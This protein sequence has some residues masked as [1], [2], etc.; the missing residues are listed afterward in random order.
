[1]N[2]CPEAVLNVF[3]EQFEFPAKTLFGVVSTRNQEGTNVRMMRIYDIN[4][5]GHVILTTHTDSLKW[6]EFAATFRVAI[7]FV[8]EDKRT[9]VILRG[10]IKL[11]T[12][13]SLPEMSAMYWGRIRPDVK[14]IYDPVY[15]VDRP[16]QITPPLTVSEKVPK[17]SGIVTIM[18]DFWETLELTIPYTES[19]R[20]QFKLAST[21]WSQEQM[22]VG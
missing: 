7:C 15:N 18:P 3:K 22:N 2:C 17:T 20:F 13:Q 16:Y 8:S 4:Q 12:P 11:D 21:G 10:T 5:N 1:M 6:S 19:R 14:M 9:Q